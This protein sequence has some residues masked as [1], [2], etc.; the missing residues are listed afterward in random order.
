MCQSCA[1]AVLHDADLLVLCHG[2]RD[3][4]TP[5]PSS[6]RF[7]LL[8]V[9]A[10]PTSPRIFIPI[11]SVLSRCLHPSAAA[12]LRI[13]LVP[14]A[15]RRNRPSPARGEPQRPPGGRSSAP[16]TPNREPGPLPGAF[17]FSF[18]FPF[19][20]P[21]GGGAARPRRGAVPGAGRAGCRPQEAGPRPAGGLRDAAAVP[22]ALPLAQ[23]P[24]LHR[25]QRP[26]AAGSRPQRLPSPR[27]GPRS[28]RRLH[29]RAAGAGRAAGPGRRLLP[30]RRQPLRLGEA[31]DGRRGLGPQRPAAPGAPPGSPSRVLRRGRGLWWW[32]GG[33]GCSPAWEPGL[34]VRGAAGPEPSPVGGL[35]ENRGKSALRRGCCGALGT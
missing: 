24:H 3:P 12:L 28:R 27:T 14:C 30:A 35:G 4:S 2:A 17:P 8:Q 13:P 5:A 33:L 22:G 21:G 26:G 29:R 6:Q 11:L 34:R 15:G 1:Q 7:S 32:A 23:P 31:R 9:A 18:S 25:A 20:G 16:H 19:P 10:A